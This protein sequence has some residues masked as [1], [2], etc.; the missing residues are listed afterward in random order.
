M[1]ML[2]VDSERFCLINIRAQALNTDGLD[3]P[4]GPKLPGLASCKALVWI[5]KALSTLNGL[6]IWHSLKA[7]VK[8]DR[9]TYLS[10]HI[11][12]G[13]AVTEDRQKAQDCKFTRHTLCWSS[14][15]WKAGLNDVY[16]LQNVMSLVETWGLS[17]QLLVYFN[18]IC[19]NINREKKTSSILVN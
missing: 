8:C 7:T 12:A 9:G 19:S 18:A 13:Y 17:G 16:A 4:Q 6:Y 3:A 11:S 10:I 5:W 2:P 1:E 14:W 15:T